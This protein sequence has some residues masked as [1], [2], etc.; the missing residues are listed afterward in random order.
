MEFDANTVQQQ[1]AIDLESEFFEIVDKYQYRL[2]E[3]LSDQA[4]RSDVLLWMRRAPLHMGIIV[5]IPAD[6]TKECTV[7]KCAAKE[8]INH[9]KFNRTINHKLGI[10][11]QDMMRGVGFKFTDLAKGAVYYRNGES[12]PWDPTKVDNVNARATAL[13]FVVGDMKFTPESK[14]C[15]LFRCA[16]SAS[17]LPRSSN[18]NHTVFYGDCL[19]YGTINNSG[20]IGSSITIA[21][22]KLVADGIQWSGEAILKQ[23]RGTQLTILEQLGQEEDVKK[24]LVQLFRQYDVDGDGY[25]DQNELAAMMIEMHINQDPKQ[26]LDSSLSS[27]KTNKIPDDALAKEVLD[28]L[29]ADKNGTL[30]EAEFVGWLLTGLKQTR[31]TLAHFSSRGHQYKVLHNFLAS[32]VSEIQPKLLGTEIK[33][34]G[35]VNEVSNASYTANNNGDG[36]QKEQVDSSRNNNNNINRDMSKLKPDL[37]EL[38]QD[39]VIT[40]DEALKMMDEEAEVNGAAAK[41]Q[42]L[43]RGK[44]ARK[45]LKEKQDAAVKIQAIQR[46]KADR[47][48]VKK[49]KEENGGN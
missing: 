48:K 21:N 29:D 39:G 25:I 8:F 44:A 45:E 6:I 32:V 11:A 28:A 19:Y 16:G 35:K 40:Y 24:E 15:G 4:S 38:I 23:K 41:I 13:K 33:G 17:V 22:A 49:M 18:D 47:E 9:V 10:S 1:V 5:Q 14:G 34:E 3:A 36:E 30:E 2:E 46:G 7:T 43:Q 27:Q 42:A 31:D 37:Q 26:Q 20:Y 12:G